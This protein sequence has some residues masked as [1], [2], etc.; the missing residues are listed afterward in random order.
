MT[1]YCNIG[2]SFTKTFVTDFCFNLKL[3]LVFI[4]TFILYICIYSIIVTR[5]KFRFAYFSPT[6][7]NLCDSLR[8][9]HYSF[10]SHIVP[11]HF[12]SY[13]VPIYFLSYIL[14]LRFFSYIKPLHFPLYSL[15]LH[16]LSY[17]LPPHFLY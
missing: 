17:S 9:N 11:L 5:K 2:L 14:P 10:I 13:I 12:L 4:Y 6:I 1:S 8:Y 7:S 3:I 15:S 16:F